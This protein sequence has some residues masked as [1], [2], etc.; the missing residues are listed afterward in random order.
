M[1]WQTVANSITQAGQTQAPTSDPALAAYFASDF[2]NNAARLPSSV[3]GDVTRDQISASSGG[4]GGG[5]G[6][7]VSAQVKAQYQP[8]A[9]GGFDF[10]GTNGQQVSPFEYARM[11]KKDLT[12]LL[13]D[14]F[15][16]RDQTFVADYERLQDLIG[17]IYDGDEEFLAGYSPEDASSTPEQL[18]NRFKQFYA[19]YFGLGQAGEE[20]VSGYGAFRTANQ[21]TRNQL[22]VST[23]E[24]RGAIR[25]PRDFLPNLQGGN[26]NL[27]GGNTQPLNVPAGFQLKVR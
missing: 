26:V 24:G 22:A 7:S 6:G 16:P 17:A 1:D 25:A 23:P 4:G 5:G 2:Q 10:F 14:S 21:P 19:D 18:V 15:D 8:N 20:D 11:T 3:V 12:S 13:K 27:Q 9:R